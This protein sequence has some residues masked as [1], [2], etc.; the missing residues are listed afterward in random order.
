VVFRQHHLCDLTV[1]EAASVS[2][3]NKPSIWDLLPCESHFLAHAR[4][5][6]AAD[7]LGNNTIGL[8]VTTKV[9]WHNLANHR[10]W[11]HFNSQLRSN[12]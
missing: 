12:Q 2:D 7:F 3:T 10:S 6:I 9:L 8:K 4:L 5:L 11:L 1:F